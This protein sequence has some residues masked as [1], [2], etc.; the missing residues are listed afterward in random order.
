MLV[1]HLQ[2]LQLS[3]NSPCELKDNDQKLPNKG[4]SC[5]ILKTCIRAYRGWICIRRRTTWNVTIIIDS[6]WRPRNKLFLGRERIYS[7]QQKIAGTTRQNLW[8]TKEIAAVARVYLDELFYNSL[9]EGFH[10]TGVSNARVSGNSACKMTSI[11]W[12]GFHKCIEQQ[13]HPILGKT[14]QNFEI[15]TQKH[16]LTTEL[17]QKSLPVCQS[18]WSVLH[19]CQARWDQ[20]MHVPYLK[21][22]IS[23]SLPFRT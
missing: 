12:L 19:D 2:I 17:Q 8:E 5:Q 10:D 21:Q 6:G 11:A 23:H 7:V 22:Q 15:P 18:R 16:L 9:E 1:N 13:R 20:S 3:F 4:P 14:L